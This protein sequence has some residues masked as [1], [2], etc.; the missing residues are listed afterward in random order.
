MAGVPNLLFD[1]RFDFCYKY[2]R[3]V[4][5][6]VHENIGRRQEILL[7]LRN[8]SLSSLSMGC[9]VVQYLTKQTINA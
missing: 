5:Y 3:E 6:G 7:G 2:F 1:L 4:P 8:N 9:Q